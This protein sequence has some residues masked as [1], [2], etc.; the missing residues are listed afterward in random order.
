MCSCAAWMIGCGLHRDVFGIVCRSSLLIS[1]VSFPIAS[2]HSGRNF[3]SLHDRTVF[4]GRWQ[5]TPADPLPFPPSFTLYTTLHRMLQATSR[6]PPL[7]MTPIATLPHCLFRHFFP[8]AVFCVSLRPALRTIS[9]PIIIAPLCLSDHHLL[10]SAPTGN[11][12][13]IQRWDHP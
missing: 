10:L 9:I 4:I 2:D 7:I 8:T 12:N 13:H 6:L 3:R 1:C 5:L 11:G